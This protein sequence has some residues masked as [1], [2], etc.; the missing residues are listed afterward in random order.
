M[1]GDE[2]R[3]EYLVQLR[4]EVLR[5]MEEAE[6][7]FSQMRMRVE[8][9][10]SDVRIGR[11]EPDGYADAKGHLLPQAEAQFLD[12]YRQL[13]KLEDKINAASRKG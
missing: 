10:E 11:P 13:L 9:M 1:S 7:E 6:R 4:D 2:Q 5:D 12:L 8:R 3:V